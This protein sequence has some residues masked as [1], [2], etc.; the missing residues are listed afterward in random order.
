MRRRSPR[1]TT[2]FGTST[3]SSPTGNRSQDGSQRSMAT[4]SAFARE[5]TSSGERSTGRAITVRSSPSGGTSQNG[6]KRSMATPNTCFARE[7]RALG[8]SATVSVSSAFGVNSM[9]VEP[10]GFLS[11]QENIA[12]EKRVDLAHGKHIV[13]YLDA[14]DSHA[15]AQ[16]IR[17]SRRAKAFLRR[18][19]KDQC[20][21]RERLGAQDI[22]WILE[23]KLD[24]VMEN[25][26]QSELARALPGTLGK[27]LP[28]SEMTQARVTAKAI[29]ED[30]LCYIRDGDQ[31]LPLDPTTGIG[32]TF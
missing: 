8:T 32:A 18:L 14:L 22:R 25:K 16:R 15:Q 1:G 7:T 29:F 24:W 31:W 30:M 13:R 4:P 20:G 11:E 10:R 3:T 27:L 26:R 2:F 17:L 12:E 21:E 28:E 5:T 9:V 6:S 19:I 23:K